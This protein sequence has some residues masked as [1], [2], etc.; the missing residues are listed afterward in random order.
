MLI[1]HY[2]PDPI[3]Q[4]LRLK[5]NEEQYNASAYGQDTHNCRYYISTECSNTFGYANIALSM[6]CLNCR[7]LDALW[8]SF[9]ELL[10]SQSP[11]GLIFDLIGVTEIFRIRDEQR[12]KLNGYHNILY[13]TRCDTSDGH[14]GVGLYINETFDYFKREDI[15]VFIPHVIESIIFEVRLKMQNP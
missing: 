4:Q 9:N 7:S 14:G 11:D 3:T 8:D 1:I 2:R 6:L 13:K 12:F 10:I 15:S 5:T